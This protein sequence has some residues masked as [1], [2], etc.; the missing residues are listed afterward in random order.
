MNQ[1]EKILFYFFFTFISINLSIAQT[2][3]WDLQ[4]SGTDAYLTD[5]FFINADTGWVTGNS[6]IMNTTDGGVSW[7]VQDSSNMEFWSIHFTDKDHGWAVGYKSSGLHGFIYYTADGGQ[8]WDFQD[9]SQYELMDIYFVGADTG[10]A[11]G[12]GRG[13]SM[14][15]KTTDAGT[16]WEELDQYGRQLYA[17]QFINDTVGWAVGEQ[18]C[19]LKTENG[20]ISWD[21]TFVDLGFFHLVSVSF[22]NQ[23]TGWAAGADSIFKTTNGGD[24][25]KSLEGLSNHRYSSCYFINTNAGWVTA[26]GNSIRKILFTPDGGNTWQVQDS[27]ENM[28]YVSSLFF[29]DDNNG[30]GIGSLGIILKTTSGGL[31]SVRDE[32]YGENMPPGQFGLFQNYPN[33]FHSLTTISY[34]L[35]VTS[36]VRLNVYDLQGKMIKTLVDKKQS[37]GNY[38][39]IFDGSGLSGGI[40][41]YQLTDKRR[42]SVKKML[43][44]K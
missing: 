3:G 15:L 43:L 5:V 23:D 30:W 44:L 11:V 24:T 28:H 14:L 41:Y 27:T 32:G 39:L 17:V 33:P 20:G 36:H 2:N 31:V 1:K 7:T 42:V 13:H 10:Y 9:S 18:G 6:I 40:Y 21:K 37:A 34:Q 26:S 4:Q 25:W 22:V 8:S 38:D 12:G 35:P 19:I 29:I 16:T